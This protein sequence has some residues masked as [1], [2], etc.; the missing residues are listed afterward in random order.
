MYFSRLARRKML[1]KINNGFNSHPVD[2]PNFVK[3][4]S[5]HLSMQAYFRRLN[6]SATTV[7]AVI[8][9]F[10]HRSKFNRER[11]AAIMIQKMWR[12][13]AQRQ[14]YKKVRRYHDSLN[15]WSSGTWLCGHS[16]SYSIGIVAVPLTT[17][18]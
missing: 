6:D 7:Q 16:T 14:K 17:K 18:L 13:Y 15:G 10:L 2:Q 12:G 3:G 11:A 4:C 8:R 5:V 1:A 9:G